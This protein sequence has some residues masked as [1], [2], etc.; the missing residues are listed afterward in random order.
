MPE[1]PELSY[2]Y[3]GSDDAFSLRADGYLNQA[4]YTAKFAAKLGVVVTIIGDRITPKNCFP[5]QILATQAP[6]T[7]SLY[8]TAA[9]SGW[10]G[11]PPG[12]D[13]VCQ[14]IKAVERCQA[15]LKSIYQVKQ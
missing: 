13:L 2:A 1:H 7:V 8:E 4:I 15:R 12:D 5:V 11:E 3:R 14:S 10:Q 6:A 9:F